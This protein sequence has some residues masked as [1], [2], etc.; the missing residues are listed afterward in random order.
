MDRVKTAA[1]RESYCLNPRYHDVQYSG[2]NSCCPM[3]LSCRRNLLIEMNR[4][5]PAPE[6]KRHHQPP[7]RRLR[8][9]TIL[10][11]AVLLAS[12]LMFEAAVWRTSVNLDQRGHAEAGFWLSVL[13]MVRSSSGDVQLLNA[14]YYR[15]TGEFEKAR[16][17][18]KRARMSNV[19][20]SD[21][22][23]E[24]QLLR[25][26]TV[27][28]PAALV[29]WQDLLQH[30]RGDAPEIYEGVVCRRCNCLRH[31]QRWMYGN[32]S[33]LMMQHVQRYGQKP[34]TC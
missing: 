23:R 17:W 9:I 14:T 20:A 16:E 12:P 19:A 34:T 3:P 10:S 25:L 21:L 29:N 30:P 4:S 32:V 7:R 26:Q 13:T 8:K 1:A 6:A 33:T 15:R 27:S 24:E 18:L 31:S 11:I 28:Q 2:L 22:D 5:S